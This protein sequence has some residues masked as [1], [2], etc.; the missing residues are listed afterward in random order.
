MKTGPVDHADW[1][2]KL[3]LGWVQKLRF[4]LALSLLPARCA[5]LLEVGYGSGVFMPSLALIAARLAG[6]DVHDKCEEVKKMLAKSDVRAD[7]RRAPAEQIP[8]SSSTFD[9]AVAVSSLEFVSNLDTCCH[10]MSRVLSP[11]GK[12]V[13]V[14]PGTSKILDFGLKLLTGENA[15]KDFGDRR[16]A[17]IPTLGRYF[18]VEE[19]ILSPP[20][21]GMFMPLYAALRLR[22]A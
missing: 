13:V 21:V 5:N 11:G 17:I 3:V 12:F 14:T 4:R 7:L 16:A 8:F 20:V 15:N 1:N 18:H 10:E 2:H 22:R 9:V 6:I 19:L